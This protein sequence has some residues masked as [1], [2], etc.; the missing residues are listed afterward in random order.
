[1]YQRTIARSLTAWLASLVCDW[2]A[3]GESYES[4]R[5]VC[6]RRMETGPVPLA[7]FIAVAVVLVVGV[8]GD[9]ALQRMKFG[10]LRLTLAALVGSS[11]LPL[12]LAIMGVS[13][14]AGTGLRRTAVLALIGGAFWVY[15]NT[16]RGYEKTR[17]FDGWWRQRVLGPPPTDVD[18]G[19]A[20]VSCQRC[21]GSISRHT[22]VCPYCRE[23]QHTRP[24]A[25]ASSG[26][27]GSAHVNTDRKS[28]RSR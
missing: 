22:A 10:P 19:P 23:V 6:S 26:V 12:V 9:R 20:P 18:A 3:L 2:E 15:P 1:M 16:R 13:A 21:G 11:T 17:A 25:I 28:I 7:A 8:V 4:D 14:D 5:S 24:P 27:H